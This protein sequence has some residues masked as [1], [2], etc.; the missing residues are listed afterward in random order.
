MSTKQ[1]KPQNEEPTYDLVG[2]TRKQVETLM[3]ASEVLSRLTMGQ[4]GDAFDWLPLSPLSE[5]NWET[6]H[7]DCDNVEKTLRKH[8]QHNLRNGNAY[9]GI[10]SHD[11]RPQGQIAF[12]L[13]QVMRHKLAWDKAI[14]DG[15]VQPGEPRKWP[16]MI[17]VTY[18]TPHQ[19]S[20]EP[21]PTFSHHSE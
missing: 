6:F 19:C 18:D 8:Y 3:A 20:T 11:I 9:L 10:H 12:D 1:V 4:V 15:I 21:L 17:Q 5:R 16:E 2:L 14:A 13:Y 7:Q